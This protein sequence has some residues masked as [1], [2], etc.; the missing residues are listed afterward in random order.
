M[1]VSEHTQNIWKDVYISEDI[2]GFE[3][4]AQLEFVKHSKEYI[5]SHPQEV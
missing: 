5:G 3:W 4:E 2:W 1:Y